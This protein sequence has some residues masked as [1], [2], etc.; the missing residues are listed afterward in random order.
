MSNR[1]ERRRAASVHRHAKPLSQTDKRQLASRILALV[2]ALLA[3][4]II[5]GLLFW[6]G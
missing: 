3:A 2:G 6:R 1:K 4:M 5:G